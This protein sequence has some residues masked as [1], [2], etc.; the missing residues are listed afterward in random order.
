M[1]KSTTSVEREDE[2]RKDSY[3][4]NCGPPMIR[5]ESNSKHRDK[6][7]APHALENAEG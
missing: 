5:I 6:V 7:N 1:I 3:L 4:C 2:E